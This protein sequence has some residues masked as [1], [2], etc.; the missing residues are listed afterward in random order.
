MVS[1]TACSM[2]HQPTWA[3]SPNPCLLDGC[4][5][6]PSVAIPCQGPCPAHTCSHIPARC[7]PT[8]LHG[9]S[10]SQCAVPCT[11]ICH[12]IILECVVWHHTMPCISLLQYNVLCHSTVHCSVWTVHCIPLSCTALY[13]TAKFS[14]CGRLITI[15]MYSDTP[16]THGYT[17]MCG[18]MHA[19]Y[20]LHC[21][22]ICST[23][24]YCNVLYSTAHWYS[25]A[26]L[27][28]SMPYAMLLYA[29]VT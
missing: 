19:P 15:Q 1:A 16:Y 8:W 27:C 25:L 22:V 23:P 17:L 5:H 18:P 20:C 21:S 7:G 26:L 2:P 14:F 28:Y 9:Q 11:G 6:R 3:P 4:C 24:I 12:S 29:R 13:I 10:P